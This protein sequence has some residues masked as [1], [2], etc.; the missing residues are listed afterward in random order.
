MKQLKETAETEV[1]SKIG[2][3]LKKAAMRECIV[4]ESNQ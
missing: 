3:K 2:L 4:P 1:K